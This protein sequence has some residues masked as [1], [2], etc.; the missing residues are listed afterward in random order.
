MANWRNL[1]FKKKPLTLT[2]SIFTIIFYYVWLRIINYINN[3]RCWNI[4]KWAFITIRF[5]VCFW[6]TH[7][8]NDDYDKFWTNVEKILFIWTNNRFILQCFLWN[9]QYATRS[10]ICN[11]WLNYEIDTFIKIFYFIDYFDFISNFNFNKNF[12]LLYWTFFNLIL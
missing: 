7:D 6:A 4:I 3:R 1:F 10:S 5:N 8:L 12:I 2:I 9:I 11:R